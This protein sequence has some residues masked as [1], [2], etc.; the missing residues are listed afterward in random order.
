MQTFNPGANWKEEF[1]ADP[2]DYIVEA[3]FELPEKYV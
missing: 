2:R 3:L 1:E